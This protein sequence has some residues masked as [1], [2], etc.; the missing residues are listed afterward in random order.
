MNLELTHRLRTFLLA[1]ALLASALR[2]A[3]A[4]ESPEAPKPQT[5]AQNSS[6]SQT[7]ATNEPV[8][9]SLASALALAPQKKNPPHTTP[10]K[11][12]TPRENFF[13]VSTPC[14]E[15]TSTSFSRLRARH[16]SQKQHRLSSR[17]HRLRLRS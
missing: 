4:Q 2:A 15:R 14:H 7:P 16:G 11:P 8:Q 1:A 9:V 12:P 6:A 5:A 3:P 13:R 17:S 10:T